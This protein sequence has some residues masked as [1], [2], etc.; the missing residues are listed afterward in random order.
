MTYLEGG[1]GGLVGAGVGLHVAA[2][3]LALLVKRLC[4]QGL[5]FRV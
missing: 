4:N 3:S 2:G 5:G 1:G